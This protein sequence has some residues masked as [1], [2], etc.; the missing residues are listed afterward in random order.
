MLGDD[1]DKVGWPAC[2]EIDIIENIGMEPAIIHGS[3][4]GPGYT[5]GTGWARRIRFRTT[6]DSPIPFMSLPSNG[7]QMSFIFTAMRFCTGPGHY[8]ATF[9]RQ[10]KHSGGM[11]CIGIQDRMICRFNL[12][13]AA[14]HS[15]ELPHP[16]RD[17][18]LPPDFHS[19][20][21]SRF[22]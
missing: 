19:A 1:I 20:P 14:S 21:C 6:S 13:V 12:S 22:R 5:G 7:S 4:H 18:R 10:R 11:L 16:W 2:G 8:L 15:S 3:I 17:A 9:A